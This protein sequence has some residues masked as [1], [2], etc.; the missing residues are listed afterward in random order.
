MNLPLK[1]YRIDSSR[2]VKLDKFDP[3]DTGPFSADDEGKAEAR[4]L[5]KK[6]K[7]KLADLQNVLYADSSHSLLVVL[8]ALDAGGKDGTIRKVTTGINPQGVRV[9]SFKAP[10]PEEL[11]HDFLWRIH[12]AVPEKGM[13]GVFN[14]SHYEDVL[15]VR[16]RDIAPKKVW[17]K[18]YEMINNFEELLLES[19]TSIIKIYL[20]ISKDEQK[21]RFQARLDNPDKHWKFNPADLADRELWRDYQKAF[22]DVFSKCSSKDAPWYIVPANHKWYRDVVVAQAMIEALEAMKL[23]Y[24]DI[25]FD[26]STVTIPD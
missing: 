6:Q 19:G 23:R 12:K 20:N 5:L 1:D 9:T 8:Q 17:S 10:T 4:K 26:P 16:V 24:P 25:D 15:V 18:R 2:R 13:V 11:A 22:E 14:R 3:D 21:E 7:K